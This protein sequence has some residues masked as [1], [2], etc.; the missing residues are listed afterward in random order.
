MFNLNPFVERDGYHVLVDVLREPG[1]RARAREALVGRA[2]RRGEVPAVLWRY[3]ALGVAWSLVAA[4]LVIL[5]SASHRRGAAAR[6][7]PTPRSAPGS[8]PT[9]ALLLAPVALL[10]APALRAAPGG[11]VRRWP[12][13]HAAALRLLQDLVDD[14]ALR[15]RFRADPTAVAEAAGLPRV[16]RELADRAGR[17]AQ[18]L[19]ARESRSGLAGVLMAAAV[20]GLALGGLLEHAPAAHASRPP[21][22]ARRGR[23]MPA[24]ASPRPPAARR[25]V[26]GLS[27]DP[28]P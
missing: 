18:A 23:T 3:G 17:A 11:S 6:R 12:D 8:P 19:E 14:P 24:A 5:V 16:A 26:A 10:L 20:E 2:P 7:C 1:L 4:A 28:S 21:A 27:L 13:E 22:S 9:W 25:C 15:A